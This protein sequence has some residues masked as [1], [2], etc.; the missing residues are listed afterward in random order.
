M[1]SRMPKRIAVVNAVAL[2]LIA[3]LVVVVVATDDGDESA[4]G[5]ETRRY[6]L[7]AEE[8]S[9][10]YAPDG[11]NAVTGEPFDEDAG[12]FVTRADD[13]VG[14]RYRK[15]L[16][17]GYTDDSFS[18]RLDQGADWEHLG[19]LGPVIHAEV[20]DTVEVV[21]LNRTK[22]PVSLHPHGLRYA[23]S[24]EGAP[25]A[26]GTSGERDRGD[27]S[28]APGERRTY[29]WEVPERAG[30]G[31]GDGSST[32]WMY[33]SH[34]DEV[35]DQYA[36]L[37]GPIIVTAAGQADDDGKPED[38]DRELVAN[39]MVVDENGSPYLPANVRGLD[40]EPDLEDETFVESNLMHAINGFVYGNGPGF[41]ATPGERVRWYL[42]GMGTEVDLHT[43]HWHG[44]TATV[45]GMRTDVASLLP[46]TMVVADME[47]DESGRWLFHCHVND[48]ISA[49]MSALFDVDEDPDGGSEVAFSRN[50][51]ERHSAAH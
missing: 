49:G 10:D 24:D 21:L 42:M 44:Q 1:N 9:W 26:D 39:F 8:A 30:P 41:Q 27:D 37:M 48:H 13:L 29:T 23:K 50:M 36:G 5:G 38:V 3:A 15:A 32:M 47:P 31:P 7:A 22:R 51:R 34:V 17:R 19:M 6:Y 2:L 45:M 28:V 4:A 40:R 43:P 11:A 16:F 46:G 14:S 25:Y 12:V 18:A 35:A 20:G 33:M